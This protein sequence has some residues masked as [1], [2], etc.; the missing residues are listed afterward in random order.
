MTFMAR[1]RL[2][3]CPEYRAWANMRNRC[4]NPRNKD[5]AYYGGRGIRVIP[6]WDEY[7]V[8]LHDMGPRP[9]LHHTLERIDNAGDY[10]PDNCRWATRAEQA[11]NQRSNR[12]IEHNGQSHCLTD[13]C[14]LLHLPRQRVID[15]LRAG[16]SFQ[17][18]IQPGRWIRR[19]YNL[20]PQLLQVPIEPMSKDG[21][22]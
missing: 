4:R 16:W 14:H 9:S 10:E 1:S 19:R 21:A 8:F 2:L 17:A 15:R 22:P 6:A 11:R 3:S 18:A 20:R 12:V 5:F 7:A 13:W